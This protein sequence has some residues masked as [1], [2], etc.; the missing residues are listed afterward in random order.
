MSV[1]CS[2]DMHDAG[3]IQTFHIRFAKLRLGRS[4]LYAESL[5]SMLLNAAKRSM[6]L[7]GLGCVRDF[8]VLDARR[9]HST[10]AFY[11]LLDS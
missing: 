6:S 4:I 2:A 11:V 7:S 1:V 10:N 3:V 5:R 8:L 9:K